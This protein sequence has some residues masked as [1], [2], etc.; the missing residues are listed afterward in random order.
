MNSK[1]AITV[2]T[3]YVGGNR[4]YQSLCVVSLASLVVVL[5]ACSKGGSEKMTELPVLTPEAGTI[6]SVSATPERSAAASGTV[7]VKAG[8]TI[9]ATGSDGTRYTLEVPGLSVTRDV[10][11]TMTPLTHVTG[12]VGDGP[13]HVVRLE[14]EGLNFVTPATLT[15]TPKNPAKASIYFSQSKSNDVPEPVFVRPKSGPAVLLIRHFSVAGELGVNDS[16]IDSA[17]GVVAGDQLEMAQRDLD[18]LSQR[19]RTAALL[20]NDDAPEVAAYVQ[21]LLQYQELI[22][23][24][25]LLPAIERM[26]NGPTRCSDANVIAQS[27]LDLGRKAELTGGQIRIDLVRAI[28]AAHANCER[29]EIVLCKQSGDPSGLVRLW[30]QQQRQLILL[31]EPVTDSADL[32]ERADKICRMSYTAVGGGGE[33]GGSG[34]ICNLAKPFTISGSGVTV[35]FTPNSVSGG[36]YKYSGSMS[37]FAVNGYGT[38]TVAANEQGG[39]ITA[40]GPGTVLTPMGSRSAN[41]TEVYTLSRK[42]PGCQ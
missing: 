9:T 31:G 38:Y 37:G 41:G 40:S 35:N 28:K 21:R 32:L 30:V 33:F 23:T 25:I 8:G 3:G 39:K 1:T 24:V 26:T 2:A 10:K 18:V 42:I 29:Q 11:V 22:Q 13:R 17:F 15:I 7:T 34:T 27:T 20:S 19:A 5:A 36:S 16:A 12:G 6:K 4:L 14:P